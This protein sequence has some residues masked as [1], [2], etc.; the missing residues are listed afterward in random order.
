MTCSPTLIDKILRRQKPMCLGAYTQLNKCELER[1]KARKECAEL[2][3]R[4][5][6]LECALSRIRQAARVLDQP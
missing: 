2:R 5:L 3:A 1:D 4:V 6:E